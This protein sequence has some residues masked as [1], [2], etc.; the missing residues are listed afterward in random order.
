MKVLNKFLK[1]GTGNY[2]EGVV[3]DRTGSGPVRSTSCETPH[4][5]FKIA[6]WN[7]GTMR[8]RSSEIVETITRRNIDLCC[9]QEVRW[10]GASA[11]HITGKDSR[12]KFFW[13]GNN[14]G[15][16]GVGVL[17][18]EKWVDKVY[19]IKRVS[20]RIMLI[21]LLVGEA[22]LTVL[23]V[24]A[25]QTG[26]EESTK[27]AFYDSL[28]TVI[29][30]LPDKEIVIPCGDWNGHVGREAAGYEGVHGGSG[31]GERNADGD[32]VLEFAVAND[33]VIGNT[34]FVKRDSHLI[35]YQSGNAKTQID[36]ILLRKVIPSEECVPQ[37]KLLICELR[38]KTSKPHPKPFSPKLRYWK[39]KEPTVQEE[40]KR[41]FKSKVNAFN[42][43][44]ASTEE[45]WNQLKT[46]LLDTTNE[47]CDKTKKR[48]HKRETWWWNDEVNSAIAEKR[49][50]W[51]A[52]KQGGGKEQ[53]L[54]AKQNAKRTVYTAKKTAEEKKFSDLK[55]GMDNIFKIA[56]QLRKDIQDVVGDKCVKDDSGKLSFDNEAKKVAW[57]QHYERL[58]NE[59]FSWNP[60]DLTADPV[61]GP[62]I[63]IDVEMVVK[64]ITKMKTGKAAGPSGI[65]AEMLKASGD[66]GARLV[67]DL[68]NDMV[69][70]GV[71]PSDW[72]DSF[73]INIYKGKGDALERGNYRGLKLLFVIV[74][75]ALSCE[76]RTGTPWELL[77]ADDLVISAET[78]EGLKMKLNKWK[79]EM[80]AKGLRVNMGKTKIMVSGVNLQTLKDSGEYPCSVCRKGVGSNSIYCAGCSH[81]VHKKCS[82]VTDS[83]KSNPDYRC[84]RCKGTARP[85]DG[86][87]HNEWLLMQDKKLDVVDSFCYLGDTIGAGGGCDLSVITRI[88][89]AWGKFR[90]LLPILT[91]HALSY[92]T[93]GQIYSTY[94]RT[95]LLYASECWAPN[96]NDLLKLQR[97]DRAM[98]RWT[99]NVRLKDHISSDSLLRKLGINNIQTLLRYNRLRWFGHVVRND[100]CINSITEFEVVGQRGRGRPKKTWK[101]TINNDL[102]HWKLSR[103]DPAN[104]MEWR[105]KLRTNIGAVRPTLSGTDTLNE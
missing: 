5:T 105:K 36:F 63:H 90:E 82:G 88:R 20:D 93:R 17:L 9:V 18:A 96:V 62:P 78:E 8:D 32:R 85:I 2:V 1:N 102:R 68:A 81:W 24:Y 94:I 74:L 92:I 11:R 61:V 10:R 4:D 30:E 87:P 54:Q 55:P 6:S 71:I 39:L 72:E 83:L 49:R 45:I 27:D 3:N 19:D 73:I 104:R 15:T 48:H 65:V 64:A 99:C 12:Y 56:K 47:T 43:V 70:N 46:A 44:E 80:E 34:F 22:V 25:P 51:K 103:A 67:A 7:I 37:H 59:E 69:R 58:L 89:S 31:Y 100:G 40:Y 14:Q 23:S 60:E 52:W 66:T 16:S 21:K 77:Y 98:I 86:R 42:N 35:T 26:L 41:V 101:D 91:S 50:C 75:E 84:S 29:S 38:L 53:Y 57:K 95:V 76:F 13:V 33:F 79:T 97:N 28:Q